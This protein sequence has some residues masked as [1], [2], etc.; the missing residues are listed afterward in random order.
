MSKPD[1]LSIIRR[2]TCLV[3]RGRLSG[4]GL[5]GGRVRRYNLRSSRYRTL[6]GKQ[7]SRRRPLAWLKYAAH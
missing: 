5:L 3:E 4:N 1:R 2:T 7:L 6:P